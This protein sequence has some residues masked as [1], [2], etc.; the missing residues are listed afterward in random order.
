MDPK[1][2]NSNIFYCVYSL[3]FTTLSNLVKYSSNYVK[4]RTKILEF[5]ILRRSLQWQLKPSRIFILLFSISLD[6]K[7]LPQLWQLFH[8]FNFSKSFAFLLKIYTFLF[9]Y[10]QIYPRT[11]RVSFAV[12]NFC[13]QIKISDRRV[14]IKHVGK[15]TRKKYIDKGWT[16]KGINLMRYFSSLRVLA[17]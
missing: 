7:F 4:T 16:I 6:T 14:V 13:H 17:K 8:V 1:H 10:K 5:Q 2:I 3:Y 15:N 9:L 11:L 12:N